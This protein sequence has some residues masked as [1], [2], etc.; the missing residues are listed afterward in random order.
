MLKFKKVLSI[1]TAAALALTLANLNSTAASAAVLTVTLTNPTPV[2]DTTTGTSV[3]LAGVVGDTLTMVSSAAFS[4]TV[5]VNFGGGASATATPQV[6]ANTYSVVIPAGALTGTV[7]IADVGPT[8]TA[9]VAG[10]QIWASRSEPYVMPS[11]HLNVTYGDLQRILDQIKIGEAHRDRT[12]VANA[13]TTGQFLNQRAA[14]ASP[15]FPSDV[16]STTR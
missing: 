1:V 5:S 13:T 15:I 3:P 8:N 14:A 10:Y 12:R 4:G 2:S 16:T 11:G 6:A 7:S 9:T